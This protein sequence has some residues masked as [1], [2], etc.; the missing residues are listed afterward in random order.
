MGSMTK[1]IL[2]IVVLVGALGVYQL[3]KKPAA[4]PVVEQTATPSTSAL[5][6]APEKFVDG[7]YVFDPASSS[8][9]WAGKKPLIPGYVDRGIVKIASG[10]TSVI[11]G[12]VTRGS[13]TIDMR[14]ISTKSTGLGKNESMM[15]KHIKSADFFDVEKYPSA[16]FDF[17]SLSVA[18][19]SAGY[20]VAGTLTVKGVTKP[21]SFPA[22]V[23]QE[24][25]RLIMKATAVLDRTQW[26][27]KYGSGKFF[28]KLGNAL[29]DDMFSVE[30]TAVGVRKQ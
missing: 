9:S 1:F 21:V 18:S 23:T 20:V 6:Q 11:A 10:S 8:M 17:T 28:D 13:V 27:I 7:D 29:I 16:K 15:E 12:T 14:T 5:A 4:A 25:S 24:G 2:T 30:F 3:V 22:T 19:D 26:D